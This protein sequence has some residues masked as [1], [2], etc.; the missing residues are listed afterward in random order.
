MGEAQYAAL[1]GDTEGAIN[2]IQRAIDSGFRASSDFSS[3]VF[4]NMRGDPRF[5]ELQSTL[6][7]YVDEERAKLGMD[8]YLPVSSLEEK[9][10][11][12]WQ[13]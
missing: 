5:E 6:A 9:K 8:P 13:P 10:G 2:A 7:T 4:Q 1:T 11:A 3:P 12:V